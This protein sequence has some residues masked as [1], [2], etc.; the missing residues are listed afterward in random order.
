MMSYTNALQV[1]FE[2]LNY[3]HSLKGYSFM[4]M[5]N[6]EIGMLLIKEYHEWL[7]SL[8]NPEPHHEIYELA[9][10]MVSCVLKLEKLLEKKEDESPEIA[11][12]RYR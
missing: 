8:N 4:D 6:D 5:R 12:G 1:F 7:D 10:I 9:D 2:R 11:R 3:K